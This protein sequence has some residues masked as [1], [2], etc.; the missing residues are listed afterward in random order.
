MS[1]D[2][3]TTLD[4][5]LRY[6]SGGGFR[7]QYEV[8]KCTV[9]VKE[10][11]AN[12]DPTGSNL[13]LDGDAGTA[14]E[15]YQYHPSYFRYRTTGCP[16]TRGK[17]YRATYTPYIGGTAQTAETQ[18]F[19]ATSETTA[20]HS[21]NV[22]RAFH[23]LNFGQLKD[24]ARK[25]VGLVDSS[26]TEF[27]AQEL[28]SMSAGD[29]VNDAIEMIYNAHAWTFKPTDRVFIDQIKNQI[30]YQLPLNFGEL[31]TIRAR[32]NITHIM[33]RMDFHELVEY[34]EGDTSRVSN[35]TYYCIHAD[36]PTSPT[37]GTQEAAYV[38]YCLYVWPTPDVFLQDFWVVHYKRA[39]RKMSADTDVAPFPV[40]YAKL[41]RQAV[42][43]VTFEV[44][45]DPVAPA[46]RAILDRMLAE[47]M[48]RDG[49]HTET[50][51]GSM[52][53]RRN[54]MD[55]NDPARLIDPDVEIR[56]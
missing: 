8:D 14:P 13:I 4:M 24:V 18:D 41:L 1:F 30:K 5:T 15:L 35:A 49:E 52:V 56:V 33:K 12:G 7:A 53:D 23:A 42:R 6:A 55:V 19:Y 20:E 38:A 34:H 46:E 9:S 11:D 31:M 22:S 37:P 16:F 51:F 48:Q 54:L 39:Y 28:G 26:S 17:R 43:A 3:G 45:N 36:P 32:A 21:V 40:G 47:A 44:E 25:A 27:A 50:N 2:L 29:V 10:L